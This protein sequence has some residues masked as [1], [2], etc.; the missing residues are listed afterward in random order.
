MKYNYTVFGTTYNV[1]LLQQAYSNGRLALQLIDAEG[2]VSVAT[3]NI[4]EY[5]LKADEVLIKSW[6]ENEGM[7]EFLVSNGIVEDTG[8][9]ALSGYVKANVCRLLI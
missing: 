1:S 7:L 4:P 9:V 5:N 2:P 8:R 3:V 6:G